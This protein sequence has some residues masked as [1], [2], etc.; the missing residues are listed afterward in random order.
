MGLDGI[1]NINFSDFRLFPVS[2]NRTTL[3]PETVRLSWIEHQ[4]R[5]VRFRPI[6]GH[7]AETKL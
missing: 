7:H 4:N 3:S 6:F 5:T 2:T 1:S